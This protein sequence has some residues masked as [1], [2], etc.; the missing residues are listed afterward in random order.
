MSIKPDSDLAQVQEYLAKLLKEDRDDDALAIFMDLLSTMRQKNNELELYN[1]K[2]LTQ[3]YRKKGEG[4][5]T[6]QLKLF[7]EK[8]ADKDPAAQKVLERLDHE[9][10][11]EDD[12]D[13]EDKGTITEV[14]GHIRH[15]NKRRHVP[16]SVE[17]RAHDVPVKEDDLP[18]QGCGKTK[19]AFGHE[20][21][22]ILDFEPARFVLHEYHLEKVRCRPCGAG[23][24]TAPGP[25]K[26]IEGGLAGPG[27]LATILVDKYRDGLP[28]HRQMDRFERLGMSIPSSTLNDW[29]GK[30]AQALEPIASALQA[31]AME[32][33]VLHVDATG[34]SMQDRDHPNNIKRGSFLAHVGDNDVLFFKFTPNQKREGVEAALEGRTGYVCADAAAVYNRLFAKPDSQVIEL[35]CWMHSRRNF[36]DAEDVDD[37]RA[38]IPLGL[39]KKLYRIEARFKNSSWQ[40]RT[41]VRQKKSKPILKELHEWI[42]GAYDT[43]AP[44]TALYKALTYAINQWDALNRYVEDG[45]LPIDNGPVER[46]ITSVAIGRKNYLFVGSQAG[47][48]RAAIIYTVLGSCKLLGLD[49]NAYLRDVFDKLANGWK[50]SQLEELLPKQWLASRDPPVKLAA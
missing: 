9:E 23:L 13:D 20:V 7:L 19:T 10:E 49:P 34:I 5:S 46:A 25:G 39:I 3:K 22:Q 1:H 50:S 29:V 43:E 35:G 31:Q 28:L 45:R 37:A 21:C 14:R 27:L 40:K 24:A 30:A 8:A 36:K 26:I 2:L 33:F 15:N 17:R 12:D 18:C 44:G 6:A 16:P 47:G 38:S 42:K 4:I 48:E 41:K 32:A 11:D